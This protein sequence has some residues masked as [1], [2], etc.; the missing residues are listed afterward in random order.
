MLLLVNQLFKEEIISLI[1]ER[2]HYSFP[3]QGHSH[4]H[5]HIQDQDHGMKRGMK[6]W[7]EQLQ[8]NMFLNNSTTQ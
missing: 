7:D 5:S 3:Q 8:L 2:L 4:S 6:G 1:L